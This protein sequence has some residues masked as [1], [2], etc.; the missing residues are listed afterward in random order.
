MHSLPKGSAVSHFVAR[1]TYCFVF[2]PGVSARVK[3]TLGMGH[4]ACPN[5]TDF[6]VH[7][8]QRHP[9]FSYMKLQRGRRFVRWHLHLLS[10]MIKIVSWASC[11]H[12]PV[13]DGVHELVV[14][15]WHKHGTSRGGL[16]W[17]LDGDRYLSCLSSYNFVRR[18][19]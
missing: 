8:P 12:A 19:L 2:F 4:M 17:L 10:D 14:E 15:F 9:W 16:Y 11:G 3:I 13:V 7:V 1:C 5:L 18:A 6:A